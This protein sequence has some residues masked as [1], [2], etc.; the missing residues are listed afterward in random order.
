[1]NARRAVLAPA[2]ATVLAG[3]ASGT[4]AAPAAP[5]TPDSAPAAPAPS[6]SPSD[7]GR[8]AYVTEGFTRDGYGITVVDLTGRKRPFEVIAG[9][10]PLGIAVL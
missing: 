9:A 6:Q 10:R 4:P 8:T 5:R 2:A 7:D 3:C 1:M